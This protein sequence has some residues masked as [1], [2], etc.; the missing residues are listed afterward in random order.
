MAS[1]RRYHGFGCLGAKERPGTGVGVVFEMNTRICGPHVFTAETN[2]RGMALDFALE[3]KKKKR[4]R[5]R[6]E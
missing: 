1:V 6:I 5:L 4:R 3:V 2:F